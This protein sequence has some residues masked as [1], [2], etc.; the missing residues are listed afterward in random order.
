M[1]IDII[2]TILEII[3]CWIESFQDVRTTLHDSKF[4]AEDF[5]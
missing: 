4:V 5:I 2:E 1:K 3:Y